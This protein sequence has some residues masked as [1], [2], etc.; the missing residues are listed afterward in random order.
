LGV[1]GNGC[2]IVLLVE[3][4][5]GRLR[6]GEWD[7]VAVY[8]GGRDGRYVYIG[9][10]GQ[11]CRRDGPWVV[12]SWLCAWP[13]I[14]CWTMNGLFGADKARR[15]GSRTSGAVGC[16]LPT[17]PGGLGHRAVPCSGVQRTIRVGRQIQMQM[18]I[19]GLK[20]QPGSLSQPYPACEV[21]TSRRG[22]P[23]AADGPS[24]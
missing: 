8:V 17:M 18:Q 4:G 3:M 14:V 15:G 1:F 5:F 19:H 7:W 16:V 13:S 11:A 10:S 6:M 22:R 21:V 2:L 23:E 20:L 9:K 12:R 24:G